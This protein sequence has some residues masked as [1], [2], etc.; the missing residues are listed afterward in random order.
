MGILPRGA[1]IGPGANTHKGGPYTS[2]GRTRTLAYTGGLCRTA[3]GHVRGRLSPP[4]VA[5]ALRGEETWW[6]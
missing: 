2:S 4:T 5:D 6:R 1:P 3:D